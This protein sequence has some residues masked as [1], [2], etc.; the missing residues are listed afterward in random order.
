MGPVQPNML[1]MPKSA[2]AHRTEHMAVKN[3]LQTAYT[4]NLARAY[5]AELNPIPL[6]ALV[7]V[8]LIKFRTK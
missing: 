8:L 1:N 2:T 4:K 6:G 5:T 7:N 3:C